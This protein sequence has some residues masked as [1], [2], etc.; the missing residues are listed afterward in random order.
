MFRHKGKGRTYSH[1]LKLASI[2]SS[3]AGMV[4]ITGVLAVDTLTTNVTGHFAFFSEQLF[5]ENYQ[6]AFIY[7]FYIIFFLLGA[8]ISGLVIEWASKYRLQTSY[9]IPISIE[10]IILIMTA[11]VPILLLKG[12]FSM[13][14]IISFALLFAMGLQNAL[15]TKVSQSVVRTT[16]LTGLFTDL[17]IELSQLFF[18]Y[19]K[20]EKIRLYKSIFLKLMIISC[21]F[22]GGIIGGFT[23]Q[24]F[25]LKT[26]LIPTGL[27]II[28]LWYD[29]ILFRYYHLKRSFRQHD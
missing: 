12:N 13:S 23:F 10:A 24:H 3:V 20:K 15:V 8:F 25:E 6:M 4:N 26:L 29:Q 2:L 1:N 9:T 18:S 17:G 27:L 7:L 5:L 22:L 28:A 16:H 11:F 19:E 21:F 14:I